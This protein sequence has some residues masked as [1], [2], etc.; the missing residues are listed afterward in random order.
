MRKTTAVENEAERKVLEE[1]IL[2]L[3]RQMP[4]GTSLFLCGWL[5]KEYCI[6]ILADDFDAG[7][8]PEDV[9]IDTLKWVIQELE[10]H[11]AQLFPEH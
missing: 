5:K 3:V 4:K 1:H 10:L 7:D 8:I 9:P 6:P 2:T 11:N